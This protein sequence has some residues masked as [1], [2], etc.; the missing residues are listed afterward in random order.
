MKASPVHIVFGH[1]AYADH[2]QVFFCRDADSGLK[3]VIAIHDTTLGPAMGGTRMWPY[4]SEGAALKDALRLSQGMTYKNALAGTKF[5][6]GKAVVIGDAKKDKTPAL[7]R[8]LGRHIERLNGNFIT[9]EDVGITVADAEEIRKATRHVRGIAEGRAGDPSP[10]TAFGV[11]KGIEAAL[12]HRIGS[13]KLRGV[14]ICIQ[15]LGNVGMALC[16]LLHDAGAELLVAD[17]RQACVKEACRRFGATAILP[18]KAHAADCDVFSPCALGGVLSEHTIPEIRA[19]VVA[20]S[21]NNQLERAE[22]GALLRACGILYAPDYV[23][24]AGGVISISHEG[25]DFELGL[26]RRDV[27]R[28]GETLALIFKRADHN[29]LPT[30]V[31]ADQLAE[32]R[33]QA[34]RKRSAAA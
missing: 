26:M 25:P 27:A 18:D 30:S 6:G 1:E 9:G 16:E 2:E 7:L 22:D 32:E 11:F 19:G 14:S 12:R 23:I 21:A 15:G 20:G 3:A 31:V 33:L 4:E 34:G 8:A 10:T 17:I 24:N 13:A 28:I 5:G 29:D